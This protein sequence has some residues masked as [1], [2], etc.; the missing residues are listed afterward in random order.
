MVYPGVVKAW[1]YHKKQTDHFVCVAGMA[2]VGLHDTREGSPTEGET[3]EFV[4]GWQRQRLSSSRPASTTASRRSAPSLPHL[5]IPTELYDHD[6]PDEYR[7]PFDDPVDR[8]RL[9]GEERMRLLVCGG[10]GFIG[11]HFVR[12]M[13]DKHAGLAR[14][15]I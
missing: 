12:R 13:L 11:S 9:G 6:D 15:S 10:A 3:N 7:L 14:S 2:K 5:N 1:H 8:L 4:I